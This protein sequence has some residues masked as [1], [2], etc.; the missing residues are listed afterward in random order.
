MLSR[1]LFQALFLLQLHLD[2]VRFDK[3]DPL[4]TGSTVGSSIY[5]FLN[6]VN[7]LLVTPQCCIHLQ[8]GSLTPVTLGAP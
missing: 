3:H 5:G 2:L 4:D 8:T 6:R 1:V 7:T